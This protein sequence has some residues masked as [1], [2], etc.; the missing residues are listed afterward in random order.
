MSNIPVPIQSILVPL[1]GST[2][3]EQAL[4]WAL[5]LAQAYQAE[6]VILRVGLRPDVWSVQDLE[7]LHAHQAEQEDFSRKYL[8]DIEARLG[9]RVSVPIRLEYSSGNPG[10]S[11]IERSQEL[12]ISLIVMN[13]HGREGLSRWLLGS[14]AERVS[15]HAPCP[16]FLVRGP[17]P[18]HEKDKEA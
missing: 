2:V 4:P 15:R 9:P 10:K 12:G 5:K 16:V 14:V 7:H 17:Q 13:S 3:S 1:D 8:R 11:I 18:P 6:L